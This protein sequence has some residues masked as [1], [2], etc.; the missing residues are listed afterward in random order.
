LVFFLPLAGYWMLA[1]VIAFHPRPCGSFSLV[2]YPSSLWQPLLPAI[3]RGA[4]GSD[5]CNRNQRSPLIGHEIARRRS[6]NRNRW[7]AQVVSHHSPVPQ[8]SRPQLLAGRPRITASGRTEART[9]RHG[10]EEYGIAVRHGPRR[11]QRREQRRLRQ[12]SSG[13]AR[14]I[15]LYACL[16]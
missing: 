3:A 5:R 6:R 9:V 7:V 10:A 11:E 2:G 14:R 15:M 4:G 13:L 16:S 1:I 12:C 8:P